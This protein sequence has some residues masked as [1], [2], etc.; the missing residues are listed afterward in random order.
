[1][2]YRYGFAVFLAAFIIQ[3]TLAYH[4]AAFGVAP[5]LVLVMVIAFSFLFEEK[6]GMIFGILFGLLQ[7]VMFSHVVGI[8]ALSYFLVALAISEIKRYLYRDNIISVAFIAI[9]GTVGYNL[10]NWSL[11]R[12]FGG[13]YGFLYFLERLPTAIIFNMG[14]L[15]LAYWVIVR[16]VIKYRGFKYM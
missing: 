1:M 6:H 13:I 15:F 12:L 2:K 10:A 8:S 7:D 16:K 4:I 5:N 3:S 14:F 9:G 11:S